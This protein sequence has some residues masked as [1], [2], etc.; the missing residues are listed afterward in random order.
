MVKEVLTESI[1]WGKFSFISAPGSRH[2]L[3]TPPRRRDHTW[4]GPILQN[5]RPPHRSL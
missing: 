5:P 1:S 4:G 3:P 2:F